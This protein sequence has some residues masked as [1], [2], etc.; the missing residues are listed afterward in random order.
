MTAAWANCQRISFNP[1]GREGSSGG[2]HAHDHHADDNH[3]HSHGSVIHCPTLGEF[4]PIATFSLRK[5]HRVDRLGGALSAALNS[6]FA[7]FGSD[8]LVHGPPG[9]E[10]SSSIPP[11]L[12]LSVLRI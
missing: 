1:Q 2:T 5:D 12:F 3:H 10:H 7:A 9:F 6:Q 11:Y 8:R 4:V